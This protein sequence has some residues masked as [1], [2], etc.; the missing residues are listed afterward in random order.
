MRQRLSQNFKQSGGL[1]HADFC[2]LELALEKGTRVNSCARAP[3]DSHCLAVEECH[4]AEGTSRHRG[5]AQ[6]TALKTALD[7]S[8]ILDWSTNELTFVKRAVLKVAAVEFGEICI[9]KNISN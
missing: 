5:N 1:R 2:V 9:S 7:K 3:V 6:I 4:I 8:R